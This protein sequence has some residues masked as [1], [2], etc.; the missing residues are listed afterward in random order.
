MESRNGKDRFDKEELGWAISLI[1]K[2][3]LR[4]DRNTLKKMSLLISSNFDVNCSEEDIS[5]FF[6][7]SENYKFESLKIEFYD[8]KEI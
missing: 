8:K 3:F 6:G 7:I 1:E 2:E 5:L 4:E